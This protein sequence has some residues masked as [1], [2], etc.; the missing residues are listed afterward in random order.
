MEYKDVGFELETVSEEIIRAT[1]KGDS[2]IA[3]VIEKGAN[4]A[5]G[6]GFPMTRLEWKRWGRLERERRQGGYVVQTD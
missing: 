4:R 5:R 1:L 2:E 6:S 3:G